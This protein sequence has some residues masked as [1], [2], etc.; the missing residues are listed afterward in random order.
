M[1]GPLTWPCMREM[2]EEVAWQV[3]A[4]ARPAAAPA[5]LA[6]RPSSAAPTSMPYMYITPPTPQPPSP[7]TFARPRTCTGGPR[8]GLAA[9]MASNMA[10]TTRDMDIILDDHTYPHLRHMA[11]F[12]DL[13]PMMNKYSIEIHDFLVRGG[14]MK[15]YINKLFRSGKW[16][17]VLSFVL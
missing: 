2:H 16:W 11:A 3:R 15:K 14:I 6:Q 8:T 9:R 4:A 13:D 5:F 12:S 1:A 17:Q 7:P 10:V